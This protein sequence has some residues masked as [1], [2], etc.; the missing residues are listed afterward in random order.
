MTNGE[1][2][3]SM[4]TY[5]VAVLLSPP[6]AE[7]FGLVG[8]SHIQDAGTLEE[9]KEAVAKLGKEFKFIIVKKEMEEGLFEE[10]EKHDRIIVGV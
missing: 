9:A 10:A 2:S 6:L 4:N 7:C 5:K 1:I 3:K 8:A